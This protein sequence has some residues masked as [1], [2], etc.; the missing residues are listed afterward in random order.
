MNIQQ[1][2]ATSTIQNTKTT[3]LPNLK[4]PHRKLTKVNQYIQV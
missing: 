2:K 1:Q 4:N 3:Q